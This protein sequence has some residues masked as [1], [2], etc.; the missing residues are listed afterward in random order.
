MKKSGIFSIEKKLLI[1]FGTLT[2]SLVLVLGSVAVW[3]AYQASTEVVFKTLDIRV[4]DLVDIIE[5]KIDVY[6]KFL[7]AIERNPLIKDPNISYEEKTKFLIKESESFPEIHELYIVCKEGKQHCEGESID[8]SK[9][10]WFQHAINGKRYIESPYKDPIANTFLMTFSVPAY[11]K[12]KNLIGVLGC[13]VDGLWLSDQVKNIRIGATG[14]CYILDSDGTNIADVDT[15]VVLARMNRIEDAKTNSQ[16]VSIAEFHKKVLAEKKFTGFYT[17]NGKKKIA[18]TTNF[19]LIDWVL[20]V[21]AV[22][23]DFMGAV[24]DIRNTMIIV[25]AFMVIVIL[26][27]VFIVAHFFVKPIRRTV[28]ALRQIAHGKGDLTVRLPIYGNDEITE[29]AMYF[30]ETIQKIAN[31]IRA[32]S[33]NTEKMTHIGENLA[34][35]MT[36]TTNSIDK[37][38]VNIDHV[39]EQVFSQVASVVQT[40]STV[41]R[42]IERIAQLNT[43]IEQQF[44]SVESSSASIEEMVSN[45]ASISQ[46]LKQ[47]DSLVESLSSAT[48]L[49]K[50]TVL[51]TN[52]ISQKIADASGDLIEASSVIENIASQTNL[53]AM[54]A[55][56]EAA[57][58]GEAGKGFAV[59]ADEIRKLAEESSVQGKNITHTLKNLGEEISNL[60]KSSEITEEKFN[61]ISGLSE[62]VRRMSIEINTAMTEQTNASK[63]VLQSIKIISEATASVK[64][65]SNEM[66][67]GGQEVVSE[68]SK[69]NHLTQVISASMDAMAGEAGEINEAVQTVNT[70]ATK[71]QKNIV[72]LVEEVDKFQV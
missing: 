4:N 18:T 20:I 69:L 3:K 10:E 30:N 31:A 56:I 49:G 13:D 5:S 67:S 68:M 38:N 17:L 7:E 42:I 8:F 28:D 64:E 44:E 6:F 16:S 25:G 54:N 46:A 71:N 41:K 65:G 32:V 36:S 40:E 9:D 39:K 11:D 66:Q 22:E 51:D 47:S 57:H 45:I 27:L 35:N 12:N 53:L 63:G 26:V 1:I 24:Y 33:T 2:I 55:A 59:V 60:V 61:V 72:E 29:L 37:I 21:T 58:A 62:S 19:S 14:N 52:A 43:S 34:D 23:T 15:N 70:L 48:T 50:Q